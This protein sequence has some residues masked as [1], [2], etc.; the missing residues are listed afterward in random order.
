[1]KQPLNVT[2]K[3]GALTISIGVE[4]LTCAFH[5]MEDYNGIGFRITDPSKF[6]FDVARQL[7]GDERE[8]G[9]TPLTRALDRAMVLAIESGSSAVKEV[10]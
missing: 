9:S 6:A 5:G 1:M 4:T 10:R 7:L 8:D 2:I 3:D